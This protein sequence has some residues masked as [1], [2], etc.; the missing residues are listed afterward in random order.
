[1]QDWKDGVKGRKFTRLCF[2][3]LHEQ[4]TTA[5]SGKESELRTMLRNN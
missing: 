3:A 4:F 2:G 1:M 5:P